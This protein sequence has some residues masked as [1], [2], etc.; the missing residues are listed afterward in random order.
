MEPTV[1]RWAW[2]HVLRPFGI[3]HMIWLRILVH[4]EVLLQALLLLCLDP[5]DFYRP[6]NLYKPGA[7]N[8]LGQKDN[9]VDKQKQTN[10]GENRQKQGLFRQKSGK[11]WVKP[12]KNRQKTGEQ[13]R[14]LAK[15]K[16]SLNFG[17]GIAQ[18]WP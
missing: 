6:G 10:L 14:N 5:Q 12:G 13:N 3:Q 11:K 4:S 17:F 9:D 15:T 1:T 16:V 7:L 8:R 2:Q 18:P